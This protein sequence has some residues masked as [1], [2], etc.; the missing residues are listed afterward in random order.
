MINIVMRRYWTPEEHT[1]L[2]DNYSS[3]SKKDV[4]ETLNRSW[5]SIE[6]CALRL[7]LCRSNDWSNSELDILVTMYSTCTK[8]ELLLAFPNRTW[9]S[10]LNVSKKSSLRSRRQHRKSRMDVL[11]S[12]SHES[13]YWLGFLLADGH[14]G[15]TAGNY[16]VEVAISDKDVRHLTRFAAYIGSNVSKTSGNKVRVRAYDSLVVRALIDKFGIHHRKTYNPPADT[17]FQIFHPDLLLSLIVGFF[18]GDGHMTPKRTGRIQLHA[19]WLPVLMNFHAAL[20]SSVPKI[21]G[22]GYADWYINNTAMVRL[23]DH[24]RRFALPILERKWN[25][26]LTADANQIQECAK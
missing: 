11:L 24:S 19:N 15:T 8:E 3:A 26:I 10:I 23:A 14:F 2:R 17:H 1:Y 25:S 12:D 4:M 9:S 7:G 5:P 22:Q 13:F 21:N 16:F 18:D 20:G 6:H